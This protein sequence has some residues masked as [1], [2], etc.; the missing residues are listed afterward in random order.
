MIV[1]IPREIKDHEFRVALTPDA[2]QV[3]TAKGKTVLVETHAGEGS[4]FVDQE[5]RD[6]GAKI[7]PSPEQLY[8]EAELIVKV[9]EPQP[10]EYSL[11][12]ARH[13]LMTYL[14]LA[15][16]KELTEA[17]VAS[18]CTAIAY[19]MIQDAHGRFP[20][21]QP[22]SDIAGRM[23][24]QIGAHYL[25]KHQK[26]RGVL[27]GGVP[28][29]ESGKVVILGSGNV[30]SAAT[31]VAVAMGAQVTVISISV[32]QLR[33]LDELYQGR[34]NTRV[35]TPVMVER[36]VVD[37][38][39]VIGAVLVPGARSPRL[40]ARD[41]IQ[42]MK[43]GAVIVDVSVDQG[44]CVETTRPTTHS[45]PVYW[46]HEVLHYA[47]PNIPGVVPRTSTLALT[48]AT[49][50][51]IVRLVDQGIERVLTEDPGFAT[52]INVRQGK[53]TCRAVAEAHGLPFDSFN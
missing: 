6:A 5:Y 28:G 8:A 46:V 13:V 49:L 17:L 44:G 52:G 7:V 45:D 35:A 29:V 1:G 42:R 19:E 32:E 47:V 12:H 53:V 38:D 21:L 26:G 23:S 48:N 3:L 36:A 39:L 37:A 50:P 25:E 41:S 43:P 30:G 22:M 10:Q 4:G 51:Y 11:L 33:H 16:S 34:V 20:I 31:R 15:A 14:H 40:V 2:V 27:L 9:K 24:I 18:R